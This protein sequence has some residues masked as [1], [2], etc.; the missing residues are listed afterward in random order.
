VAGANP[1]IV[2]PLPPAGCSR[3][4]MRSAPPGR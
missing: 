2:V 1:S 4:A 3:R